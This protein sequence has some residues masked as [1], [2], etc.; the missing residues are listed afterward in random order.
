MR[1]VSIASE[2][3]I[4][5]LSYFISRR[6]SDSRTDSFTSIIYRIAVA[7]IALGLG[8]MIV[9]FQILFGFRETIKDK[10]FNFASHIQITRYTAGSSYEDSLSLNTSIYRNYKQYDFIEHIQ[11]YCYKF[12]LIRTDEEVEGVLLKGVGVS[13]DQSRFIKYLVE[14]DFITF[15]DTAYSRQVILSRR[16]AQK[17]KLGLHDDLTM[18]FFQNPAR[19]RNVPVRYR[20]LNVV[21]I[22][23][24]GLEDFDDRIIIGDIGLIRRLNNWSDTLATGLEVF[25]KDRD[26]LDQ[27]EAELYAIVDYDLYVDKVTDRY[28]QIFEWLALLSRNVYIFIVLILLVACFNM[29]SILLILIMER[30]QMIGMLKALGYP[31]KEVRKIFQYNGAIITMKGMLWGNGIAIAF[32]LLQDNFK[33]IPLDPANY[34]MNYVPVEWNLALFLALNLLIFVIVYLV[35]FIPT[36][37]ISRVT[38]I[39]AIRFQ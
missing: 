6:I 21:G 10:I 16:I 18:Y 29:V 15:S 5:N 3:T 4:L 11:E 25:V 37:I 32:G 12:V 23:E 22:Y 14:G 28:I 1:F 33:L 36:A 9:T 31:N 2:A 8:T 20:K 7:S 39:R 35:L 34:Y 38:P 13:Y 26:R 24:T 19:N 30:T 27:A 17:L